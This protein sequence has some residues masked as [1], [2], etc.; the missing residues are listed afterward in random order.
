M[1]DEARKIVRSQM[2]KTFKHLH[3]ELRS[4]DILLEMIE[5][6]LENFD[7]WAASEEDGLGRQYKFRVREI[8]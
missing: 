8:S 1:V 7:Q 6:S 4:L 5:E 2:V 3:L